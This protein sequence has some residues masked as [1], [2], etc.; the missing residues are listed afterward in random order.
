MTQRLTPS[1]ADADPRLPAGAQGFG[2]SASRTL[3]GSRGPARRRAGVTL[4]EMLVVVTIMALVA[5]FTSV[6]VFKKHEAAKAAAARSQI[7]TFMTALS[8]YRLDTGA[9]PDT[10]TG[11]RALLQRPEGV[12]NWDGPYL[13]KEIPRDPWG[14]AYL[15][16]HP[17]ELGD[18]PA[19][20]SLGADGQPGGAGV[21]QDIVSWRN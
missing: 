11:L 16:R 9:F 6:T 19:I 14:R 2:L 12:A 8:N 7:E 17:G 13:T 20:V 15:Y 5:G 1:C 10:A 3:G 4:I 21:N 18:L